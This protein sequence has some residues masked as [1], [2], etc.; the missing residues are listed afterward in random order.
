M[1]RYL[2]RR[3]DVSGGFSADTDWA[4]T[5]TLPNFSPATAVASGGVVPF[6]THTGAAL[7]WVELRD[8]MGDD[9]DVVAPGSMTW[10]GQ[11]VSWYSDEGEDIFAVGEAATT[12]PAQ[13]RMIEDE[14]GTAP[15][16]VRLTAAADIPVGAEAI[17]VYVD[18]SVRI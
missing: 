9:A 7:I 17:W 4:G 1:S 6:T 16:F 8:G 18:T 12:V 14:L 10:S 15:S 13:K 11:V 2:H 3:I 5:H